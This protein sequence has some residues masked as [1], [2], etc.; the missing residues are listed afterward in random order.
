MKELPS[1]ETYLLR[2]V[3]C[4]QRKERKVQHIM[5]KL[6]NKDLI[7]PHV[8]YMYHLWQ[9]RRSVEIHYPFKLIRK[10]LTM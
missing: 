9:Q 10:K 8:V 6:P 7:L 3:L 4:L 2:K 5:L 1:I